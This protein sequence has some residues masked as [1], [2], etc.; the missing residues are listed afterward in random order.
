MNI[1]NWVSGIMQPLHVLNGLHDNM[2]L[3][4]CEQFMS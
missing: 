2:N 3:L 1:M 4:N